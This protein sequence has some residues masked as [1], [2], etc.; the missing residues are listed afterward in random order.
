MR[1]LRQAV[2]SPI[3]STASDICLT[4][5]NHLDVTF[6]GGKCDKLGQPQARLILQVH[7][8]IGLEFNPIY[9]SDEEINETVKTCMESKVISDWK[10]RFG[11]HFNVP[12]GVSMK[13]LDR[14]K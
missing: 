13:I 6:E 3:Q 7:D 14:W 11:I 9:Y 4:A 8:M 5:M 1:I 2:N 12:L 10:D